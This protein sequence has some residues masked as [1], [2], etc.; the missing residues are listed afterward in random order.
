MVLTYNVCT[1]SQLGFANIDYKISRALRAA[2]ASASFP[3]KGFWPMG[4]E[5]NQNTKAT[6]I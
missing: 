5:P 1:H 4:P 3:L 2:L 6:I